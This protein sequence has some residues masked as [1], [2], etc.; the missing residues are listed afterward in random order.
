MIEK[1][2]ITTILFDLGGVLIQLHGTPF[3][4][5]W[6]PDG[7]VDE[8]V[9]PQWLRS[10]TVKLF[11]SGQ[12][13]SDEF[14]LRFI[15]EAGLQVEHDEFVE[16]FMQWPARLFPGVEDMLNQLRQTYRLAAL[17]NSNAL[18]WPMIM[19]EMRLQE[20]IPDCI[21]SHQIRVM[22]PA[23]QAFVAALQQLKLQP[24]EVLFLDD[25]QLSIDM[26]R[27]V[28]MQAVKVTGTVGGVATVRSLSLMS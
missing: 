8:G 12:I 26:A 20:F 22:K 11:E 2:R 21:S 14:V 18:H 3:K 10:D 19:Q 13:E 27:E 24:D 16:H 6:L 23:R 4:P 17:S 9:W 25:L 5:V 15:S 28:G 7:L 1:S